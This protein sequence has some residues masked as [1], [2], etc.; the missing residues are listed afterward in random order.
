MV[1]KYRKVGKKAIADLDELQFMPK[2]VVD[3]QNVAFEHGATIAK[4][5]G[6]EK[7]FSYDALFEAADKIYRCG[8]SPKIVVP[9]K[10]FYQKTIEKNIKRITIKKRE[11]FDMREIL[12]LQHQ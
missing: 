12:K 6:L 10:F 4:R 3:G 8:Y 5:L 11:I 7:Y 2:L 1:T 9:E